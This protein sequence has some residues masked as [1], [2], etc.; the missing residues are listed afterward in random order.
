MPRDARAYLSDI[1]MSC[2]AI[3]EATAAMTLEDY[4]G[5]RLVR[6]SVERE[7][8]IIGEAIAVLGRRA[9]EVRDSI[10]HAR[11]VV[12]FRNQLTHEYQRIDDEAVWVIVQRDVAVLRSECA[13]MLE[14][15]Q[16]L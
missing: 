13:D 3:L 7:F 14:G 10:T 8:I 6:S 12:A 9:P 11:R 4:V 16:T 1:V 2:D 5:S 15:L